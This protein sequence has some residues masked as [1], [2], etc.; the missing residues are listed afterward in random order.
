MKRRNAKW[1]SCLLA[2]LLFFQAIPL[3]ASAENY[4]DPAPSIQPTSSN[5]Y[6]ILFDNTHG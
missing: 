5:G 3:T 1:L 6:S 2:V 4:A